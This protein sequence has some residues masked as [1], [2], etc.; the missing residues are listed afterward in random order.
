MGTHNSKELATGPKTSQAYGT[1]SGLAHN[2]NKAMLCVN[3]IKGARGILDWTQND[4]AAA[5][6]IS[7][8]ALNNLERG[9]TRP[10]PETMRRIQKALERAGIEFVSGGCRLKEDI[11]DI[12]VLHGGE[13]LF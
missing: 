2:T 11:L 12:Q 1:G 6:R 13:A 8:P 10:P 4:L 3:Q 9:Q 7:R 5:A